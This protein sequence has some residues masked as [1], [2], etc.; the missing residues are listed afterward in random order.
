MSSS[1]QACHIQPVLPLMSESP[2]WYAVHTYP[3]H[4]RV[5]DYR[6]RQ[7]QVT[8]FLPTITETHR[9]SDRRKI[10]EIPLFSCYVFVQLVP[11]NETWLRILRTDGVIGFVGNQ[12]TGTPIPDEQIEAVRMLLDRKVACK[13][14]PFLKVGQRIR[15]RGGALDGVEGLFV[16]QNGD[17]SIVISVDAIQRSLAI[18]IN[19]YDLDVV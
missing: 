9:W 16:S 8:S 17:D 18:R 10:V 13:T 5:V 19:G 4:E 6:I 15:V 7:L 1:S 3:R 12:R 2:A 14:H 11:T